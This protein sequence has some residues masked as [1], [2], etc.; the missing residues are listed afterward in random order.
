MELSSASHTRIYVHLPFKFHVT[1]TWL[2]QLVIYIF[3]TVHEQRKDYFITHTP[4][5]EQSFR[6]SLDL[7]ISSLQRPNNFTEKGWLEMGKQ[8]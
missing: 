2:I 7:L 8:R 1:Q 6:M 3:F 5:L 4:M